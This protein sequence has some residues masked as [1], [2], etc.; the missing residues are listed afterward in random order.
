MLIKDL[1]N[2]LVLVQLGLFLLIVE[3]DVMVIIQQIILLVALSIMAHRVL[4]RYMV[5]NMGLLITQ[6]N[7]S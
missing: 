1:L 2:L 7:G 4:H 5:D 6:I 3:L